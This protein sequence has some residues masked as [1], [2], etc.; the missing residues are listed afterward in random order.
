MLSSNKCGHGVETV[1]IATSLT[2]CP[3]NIHLAFRMFLPTPAKSPPSEEQQGGTR[4]TSSLDFTRVEGASAQ[5]LS[6][7]STAPLSQDTASHSYTFAAEGGVSQKKLHL[8]R[9]SSIGVS[10]AW[11]FIGKSTLTRNE[12]LSRTKVALV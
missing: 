1:L 8:G 2:L 4:L 10:R 7:E 3:L 6:L 5:P 12:G 11:F 9:D